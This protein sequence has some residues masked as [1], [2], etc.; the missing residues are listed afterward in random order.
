[1]KGNDLGAMWEE[2][3][4]VNTSKGE[5]V[6]ETGEIKL[7]CEIWE[8]N[9][10]TVCETELVWEFWEANGETVWEAKLVCKIWEAKREAVWEARLVCKGGAVWKAKLVW[11]APHQSLLR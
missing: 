4:V 6:W 3:L 1:M 7:V 8:A 9:G 11:E 5:V 2:M 10:E